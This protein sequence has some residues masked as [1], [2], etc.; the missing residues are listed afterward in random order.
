MRFE[1]VGDLVGDYDSNVV[2]SCKITEVRAQLSDLCAAFGERMSRL[3][4]FFE[5]CAII[6]SDT[7][8]YNDADIV[9]LDCHGHLV[10]QD[11]FLGLKIVDA[12]A[13]NA[14]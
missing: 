2:R 12:S 6:G 13:L 9:P 4:A 1:A 7:V 11:V 8:D 5:F 3:A 14:S 10:L